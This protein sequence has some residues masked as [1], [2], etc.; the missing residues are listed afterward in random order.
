[1]GLVLCLPF[2][3]LRKIQGLYL[4]KTKNLK[5]KTFTLLPSL[6]YEINTNIKIVCS[7]QVS[8]YTEDGPQELMFRMYP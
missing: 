2:L 6:A 7:P 1:M 3:V 5:P 8:K 4:L